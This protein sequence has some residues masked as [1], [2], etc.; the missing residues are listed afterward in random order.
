METY[1][2][3][4]MAGVVPDCFTVESVCQL[5]DGL[6]LWERERLCMGL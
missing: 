5:S 4:R 3:L 2:E 1:G 6:G